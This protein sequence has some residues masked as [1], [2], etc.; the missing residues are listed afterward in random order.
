MMTAE[1]DLPDPDESLDSAERLRRR[2]AA[3]FEEWPGELAWQYFVARVEEPEDDLVAEW[4][5]HVELYE[6]HRK[7]ALVDWQEASW[8]LDRRLATLSYQDV[9]RSVEQ[10]AEQWLPA[11]AARDEFSARY[12]D[13]NWVEAEVRRDAAR[14]AAEDR[15]YRV[16]AEAVWPE[17]E[18]ARDREVALARVDD[19][20]GEVAA[21]FGR[22]WGM[23]LPES[24]FRFQA[25]L[26]SLPSVGHDALEQ[27]ELMPYGIMSLVED[28]AWQP[29]DGGDPRMYLRAYRD[30]PEFVPFMH[31]GSDGLHFGLWFDDGVHCDGTGAYYNNDGGGVG[32]PWGTPLLQVRGILESRW[33]LLDSRLMRS[34]WPD[35]ALLERRHRLRLLREA[36]LAF[37]TAEYPQEGEDYFDASKESDLFEGRPE[38]VETLDEAGVRVEVDTAI[39]RGRQKPGS[40]YEW[41]TSLHNEL[42]GDPA[43]RDAHVALARQRCEAGNPGDALALGR[44][45]HWCSGGD[46]ALEDLA[47]ELLTMAYRALGRDN[48]AEI[49]AA[50]HEWRVG[51]RDGG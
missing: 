41:A 47:V 35:P 37:E 4:D 28:P 23:E 22:E 16:W 2:I 50:H 15:D 43:A 19:S 18:R 10:E 17:A 3:E 46:A 44:D 25:F 1:V 34:D 51:L 7:Y 39:V 48:L 31:G 24:I 5:R 20:R 6:K 29:K 32:L 45:L 14:V 30:P 40:D 27:L 49:A 42:T 13:L 8:E 36:V 12:P 11:T 26:H 38:R 9:S 21:R 33:R